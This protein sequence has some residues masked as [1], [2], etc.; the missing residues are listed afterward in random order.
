MYNVVCVCFVRSGIGYC[1]CVDFIQGRS[2]VG[3]RRSVLGFI[4][5]I[6]C[7]YVL[8]RY[9]I[10]GYVWIIFYFIEC[11]QCLVQ[12]FVVFCFMIVNS[13]VID[14]LCLFV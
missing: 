13:E 4:G 6:G 7:I 10:F 14:S 2:D 12:I 5:Y 11:F 8:V 1:I 9:Q 3:C